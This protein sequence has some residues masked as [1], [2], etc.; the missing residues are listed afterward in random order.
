MDTWEHIKANSTLAVADFWGHLTHQQGGE[1]SG[2]VLVD[3]VEVDFMA[4]DI[5]VEIINP[6]IDVDYIDTIDVEIIDDL[7]DVEVE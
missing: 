1:G 2:F 3:T 4:E 5:D 7:I 6:T